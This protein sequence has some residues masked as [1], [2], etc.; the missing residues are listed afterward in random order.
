MRQ[1]LRDQN[2]RS[3]A[4]LYAKRVLSKGHTLGK[5]LIERIPFEDGEVSVLSP[6]HL[7]SSQIL[8]FDSGHFPQE[9]IRGSGLIS[10]VASSA[11]EL[12][13]VIS[14][15]LS[16]PSSVSLI[17]N[18]SAKPN[19]RWLQQ[20]KSF[21]VVHESEV[22]HLV[23]SKGRSKSKIEQ[24]IRESHRVPT[25]IGAV[26][27]PASKLSDLT[28]NLQTISVSEIQHIAE[29]ASIFFLGAYDGEGF[30]I[31]EKEPR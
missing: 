26:G 1:H 2:N 25:F 28:Q 31:W 30:L 15:A 8:D 10:P 14:K 20:A 17:E 23:F 12:I 7:D 21:V 24:A 6:G 18:S 11:D 13:K 9:P 27:R 29:T 5:F 3:A 4:V 22:F 19:Y 16:A